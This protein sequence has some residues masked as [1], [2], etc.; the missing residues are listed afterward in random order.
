MNRQEY[1]NT[2][3]K[4]NSFSVYVEYY[5]QFSTPLV[6]LYAK[7]FLKQARECKDQSHFNDIPLSQ[8]DSF[9]PY[10]QNDIANTNKRIGNGC[11]QSLSDCVCAL[12]VT[13]L[14][15]L[16]EIAL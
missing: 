13:V 11:V 16:F 7:K 14:N 2:I 3:T 15:M 5:S 9:Q 1:M 12:K 10:I 6:K 8:W 4:E